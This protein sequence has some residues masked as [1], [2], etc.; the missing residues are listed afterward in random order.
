MLVG[1]KRR[2]VMGKSDP[3]VP[4]RTITTKFTL[5]EVL[6]SIADTIADGIIPLKR[7]RDESNVP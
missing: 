6:P 1:S 5:D 3:N 7:S 4:F 2:I